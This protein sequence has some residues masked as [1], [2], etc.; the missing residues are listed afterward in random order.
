MMTS[1]GEPGGRPQLSYNNKKKNCAQNLSTSIM[2][3]HMKNFS[4]EV[5]SL[6][7]RH[8]R[9]IPILDEPP[10]ALT[11][12]RDYVA[13][14]RPCIIR[15]AVLSR[16]TNSPLKLTL[17]DIISTCSSKV[18]ANE[19]DDDDKKA[20]EDITLSVNV[21]PDG[22]GDCIRTVVV[23]ETDDGL[24][25]GDKNNHHMKTKKMFV[26]PEERTMSLVQF[27]D[28]LRSSSPSASRH[29]NNGCYSD[30]VDS[31][32]FACVDN[33]S[34]MIDT[35]LENNR[36]SVNDTN[37]VFYYSR[38]DDCL[39]NE[40]NPLLQRL[41][42]V[43]NLPTTF[44]FAEQAFAAMNTTTAT[45][46]KPEAINLWIGNEK[47]TS[48]MHKDFYENLYYVADGEKI[49]T[50]CPPSDSLYF[51]EREY[52]SG[53]FR[54]VIH[55]HHRG[56]ITL[57]DSSECIENCNDVR[58]RGQWI[59]DCDSKE[60]PLTNGL[61]KNDDDEF[62]T[63][64]TSSSSSSNIINHNY[65]VVRWIEPDV[66]HILPP[67]EDAL[68]ATTDNTNDQNHQNYSEFQLKYKRIHPTLSYTHPQRIRLQQGDMLYLPAL[69]Y[70]RVTSTCESVAINY[71]YDM[72]FDSPHWCYFNLLQNL[73]LNEGNDG[74]KL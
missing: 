32:Q 17:D 34:T 49:F 74:E 52:E 47:S 72:R 48:M 22:Y 73:T 39:R 64:S 19:N 14:S 59:V 67:L 41:I 57:D 62:T 9:E 24:N 28:L 8:R 5:D 15:N 13:M 11:F 38:Q 4:D 44:S 33:N 25:N 36:A 23:D 29:S 42:K 66:E 18:S 61:S 65:H 70:H 68:P 16:R 3:K 7:C 26:R 63:T 45:I 1:E 58:K 51:E 55:H 56:D 12:V 21:T 20:I 40:L 71:W 46:A 53:S 60:Q 2:Q 35:Q 30:V 43:Y 10:N 27:R 6:W 54:Q 37:A 31:P 50:I 69:W